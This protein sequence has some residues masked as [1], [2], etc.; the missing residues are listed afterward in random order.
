MAELDAVR[1]IGNQRCM[2]LLQG[3]GDGKKPPVKAKMG[4]TNKFF[5]DEEVRCR[6]ARMI[7][8]S[9]RLFSH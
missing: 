1:T 4:E 8:L 9:L 7:G 2:S 6:S 5:Y 3:P